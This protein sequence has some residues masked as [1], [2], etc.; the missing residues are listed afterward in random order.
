MARI[1]CAGVLRG[2]ETPRAGN[3]A[4]AKGSDPLHLSP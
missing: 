4:P 3:D 1:D 2:S